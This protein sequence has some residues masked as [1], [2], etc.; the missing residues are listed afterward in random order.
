MVMPVLHRIPNTRIRLF[1]LL[2]FCTALALPRADVRAQEDSNPFLPSTL[3]PN[4]DRVRIGHVEGLEGGAFIARTGDA[5]ANWYNPAGLALAEYTSVNTTSAFEWTT[6]ELGGLSQNFGSDRVRSLGGYYA[7][8]LG[9]D[10]LGTDRLRLGFAVTRPVQWSPGSVNGAVTQQSGSQT[11]RVDFYSSAE[12]STLLP[13]INAGLR[14]SAGV[15]VGG[16]IAMGITNMKTNRQVADRLLVS[17]IVRSASQSLNFDGQY[18]QMQLT[19][20]VQWDVN[21]RIRLGATLTTPGLGLG[22][23]AL[24]IAQS[25]VAGP[26]G[27]EDV[28]FRDANAPFE[29][30]LPSRAVGG[31]AMNLGAFEVEADVRYYGGHDRY[32]VLSSEASSLR[33]TTDGS[34][35]LSIEESTVIGKVHTK[36]LR[37]VSNSI[38]HARLADVDTWD[39]PVRSSRK[40]E[41]CLRFS[42]VPEGS[43][44]PRRYRCQPD[45]AVREVIDAALAT[46][47]DLG[48]ADQAELA[49]GVTMRMRPV[50]TDLRFGRPAYAQLGSSCPPEIRTGADDE[51]E[52]GAFHVLFQPQ[53]ETDLRIRLEEYLR[54]GLEAGVFHAS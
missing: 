18:W 39:A 44:A 7:G 38:L 35:E 34:G 42:Y 53:R 8:V 37:L 10:V 29:Y 50:F 2:A 41:G 28:V 48:A 3:V 26:E 31:M 20:G 1:V 14:L 51:S 13:S 9:R 17:D 25:A 4:Y 22:G 30:R 16:G 27:R 5:G 12:M 11:Q 54:F 15:R 32:E 21:D 36:L 47:P 6:I 46:D 52:M 45:L 43:R 49:A 19:A 24:L 23:S 33:V 40:Q